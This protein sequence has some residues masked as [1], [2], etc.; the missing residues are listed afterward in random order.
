MILRIYFMIGESRDYLPEVDP[1]LGSAT[2]AVN[3]PR[4]N[5][6]ACQLFGENNLQTDLIL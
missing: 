1:T 6:N 3:A 2:S 4:V 5:G